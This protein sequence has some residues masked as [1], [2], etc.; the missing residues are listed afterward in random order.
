MEAVYDTLEKDDVLASTM[1][2]IERFS[3]KTHWGYFHRKTGNAEKAALYIDPV[4]A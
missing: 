3:K 2:K 1:K 4:P